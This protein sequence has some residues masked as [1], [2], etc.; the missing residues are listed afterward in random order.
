MP[1]KEGDQGDD[2]DENMLDAIRR[3]MEQAQADREELEKLM[4]EMESELTD[5]LEQLKESQR[6]CTKLK[7]RKTLGPEGEMN[8]LVHWFHYT[9]GLTLG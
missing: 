7:V 3:R 9:Y 6:A 1:F 5:T 4:S 8:W 2:V